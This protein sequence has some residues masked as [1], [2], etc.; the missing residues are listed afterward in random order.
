MV[1][2][3]IVAVVPIAPGVIDIW[4]GNENRVR[5]TYCWSQ[6]NFMASGDEG[7]FLSGAEDL[8]GDVGE[9]LVSVVWVVT[10]VGKLFGDLWDV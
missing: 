10:V 5:R 1:V 6:Y 9:L 4:C 7:E 2:F 8:N 3:W